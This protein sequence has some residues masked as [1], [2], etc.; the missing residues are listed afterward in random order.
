M[1]EFMR[2]EDKVALISGGAR[3]MGAAEARLFA[4]EGAKVIFVDIL[5]Q[6]GLK[7][8]AEIQET[9][10]E[11]EYLHLDVTQEENWRQAMDVVNSKYGRLNILVNNAGIVPE[12]SSSNVE[13]ISEDAWNQVMDVNAKGMFL[14]T[15][16]LCSSAMVKSGWTKP[17]K[18]AA[19]RLELPNYE[20]LVAAAQR[21]E[22]NMNDYPKAMI[23]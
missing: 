14:G 22:S 11:A 2:L 5:D 3:G 4:D 7:V 6:E 21:V 17:T 8:Q 10:G 15:K 20:L 12:Y 9:G 19:D 18:V 13:G 23:Q 1:R 16:V